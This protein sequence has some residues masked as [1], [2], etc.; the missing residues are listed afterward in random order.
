MK[1]HKYL[2][3]HFPELHEIFN[4]GLNRTIKLF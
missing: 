1:F 2:G 3:S 4:V